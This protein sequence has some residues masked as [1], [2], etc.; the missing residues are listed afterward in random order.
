MQLLRFQNVE[1]E[2]VRTKEIEV[3]KAELLQR[4]ELFVLALP[5]RFDILKTSLDY[6]L[7]ARAAK[8]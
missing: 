3:P 1:E 5:R 4:R 8:R 2:L 6:G 7:V